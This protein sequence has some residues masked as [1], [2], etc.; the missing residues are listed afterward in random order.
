MYHFPLQPLCRECRL[1]R[2]RHN[3]SLCKGFWRGPHKGFVSYRGNIGGGRGLR[4]S[5]WGS[6]AL[7]SIISQIIGIGKIFWPPD[8]SWLEE[9]CQFGRILPLCIVSKMKFKLRLLSYLSCFF[10]VK[11]L[12]I[13]D[14]FYRFSPC[15]VIKNIYSKVVLIYF[16]K[17]AT[18]KNVTDKG[19][20]HW[21]NRF[22]PHKVYPT[23][24]T[25]Q[26][27]TP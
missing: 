17:N 12:D 14:T 2:P 21:C 23:L 11:S 26:E 22:D 3:T 6:D 24:P 27:V 19:L 4:R 15:S 5:W 1:S 20:W 7:I 9:F 13:A 25:H 10:F 18:E 8:F 16:Q